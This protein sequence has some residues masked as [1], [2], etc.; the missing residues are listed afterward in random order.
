MPALTIIRQLRQSCDRRSVFRAGTLPISHLFYRE[1]NGRVHG[2][3]CGAYVMADGRDADSGPNGAAQSGAKRLKQIGAELLAALQDAGRALAAEQ[4]ERL[5]LQ[6]DAAAE[7]MRYAENAFRRS[8]N[9]T[10]AGL[11]EQLADG[12]QRLASQIRGRKWREI[13]AEANDLARRRPACFAF[14]AAAAGFVVGRLLSLSAPS[15]S[16]PPR[17][18]AGSGNGLAV[19]GNGAAPA[20]SDAP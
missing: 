13:A 7:A 8:D 20:P 16:A 1:S 9:R 15:N 6:A 4:K 2:T 18:I 19:S 17:R 14:G 10:V 3:F 11:A 5:A 12:A